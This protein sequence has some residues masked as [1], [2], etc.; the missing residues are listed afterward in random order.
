MDC[1]MGLVAGRGEW[2]PVRIK[3]SRF[4]SFRRGHSGAPGG[5]VPVLRLPRR[6]DRG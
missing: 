6:V 5:F 3:L 1:V 2:I 4:V